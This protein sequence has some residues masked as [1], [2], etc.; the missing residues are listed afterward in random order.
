MKKLSFL[1]A[2]LPLFVL[3]GNS[4]SL[5]HKAGTYII[6]PSRFVELY[7]GEAFAMSYHAASP[8]FAN[9]SYNGSTWSN[10]TITLPANGVYTGGS[11][12]GFSNTTIDLNGGTFSGPVDMG[13]FNNVIIKNGKWSNASTCINWNGNW[14]NVTEQDCKFSNSGIIHSANDNGANYNGTQ[15][16]LKSYG[17]NFLRDTADH[18]DL[19]IQGTYASGWQPVC[20]N[21]TTLVSNCVFTNTGSNGT[22]IRGTFF[23][24]GFKNNKVIYTDNNGLNTV[25]GDVGV[26]YV[27]GNG[28]VTGNYM[29]GGR[30]YWDREWHCTLGG[31]VGNSYFV[32]NIKL[33]T[34]TYGDWD[35]R[36]TEQEGTY[37][38]RGG[39]VYIL[40]NTGANQRDNI[41]FWSP[42]VVVGLSTGTTANTRVIVKNNLG[43]AF[44]LRGKTP[45]VVN[46][47]NDGN[48]TS[49]WLNSD[50]SNNVYYASPA[51]IVDTLTGAKLTTSYPGIGATP[52]GGNISPSLS[53]SPAGT[54]TITAPTSS[55][56]FISSAIDPDGSISSYAW[57]KVSGPG[58]VAFSSASAA[59]TNASF[60]T[61]GTYVIRVMVTDNGGAQTTSDQTVIYNAAPNNPP[62]IQVSNVNPNAVYLPTDS[63]VIRT[64]ATDD[65]TIVG[66]T[67]LVVGGPNNPSSTG[68]GNLITFKGLLAGTYTFR[69]TVTDNNG[70]STSVD[71]MIQVVAAVNI[72]SS[73]LILQGGGGKIIFK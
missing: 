46:Q 23:R 37:I 36:S 34:E 6:A 21:D 68:S 50:S 52:I 29:K 2:L 69:R 28:V 48:G 49:T 71:V 60:S 3:A 11:F 25:L 22:E 44:T 53:V 9:P 26:L 4:Y 45:M 8:N 40:N 58:T 7:R 57:T 10:Q 42:M 47:S 43:A 5:P 39:F 17:V 65:G 66:D 67:W 56:N 73:L 41:N 13:P 38:T 31:A 1:L 32:N 62:V 12:G 20:Y 16:S 55:V 19:F 15:A 14:T 72:N 35:T 24:Y 27:S 18:S 51:G 70:L 64:T 54:T 63:V 59:S 30:G 33:S 61:T